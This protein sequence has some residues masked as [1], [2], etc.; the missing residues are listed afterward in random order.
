M[1]KTAARVRRPVPDSS[2]L[3]GLG[4]RLRKARTE[5]GLSQG[6]L[7]APH[8]TRAYISAVE[9]GKIRPSVKSLEFMAAKLGKPTSYFMEEQGA[10]TRDREVRAR[11]RHAAQLVAEGRSREAIRQLE[12]LLVV[13]SGRQRAEI[14]R[15]LGRAYTDVGD[16]GAAIAQ[17]NDALTAFVRMGDTENALR[18]RAQLGA[19]LVLGK[20]YAEASVHL[21]QVLA[22]FAAGTAKDPLV[23]LQALHHL[24]IIFY[25]RGDFPTALSHFDRA[26]LEGQDVGDPRFLGSTYAASGMSRYQ[27]GDFEGAISCFLKSEAI[28][29]SIRKDERVINIQ[30]QT[31]IA[32]RSLGNR[33]KSLETARRAADR[34]KAIGNRELMIRIETFAAACAAELGD[35]SWAVAELERLV[36]EADAT[37]RTSLRF[38]SRFG[39]GRVLKTVDPGRAENV[40]REAVALLEV[41]EPSAELADAYTELSDVLSRKGEPRAALEFANKAL[42]LVRP[43]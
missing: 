25:D 5:A 32:L 12:D 10:A 2:A 14:Q 34:A 26:L 33:A 37:D 7:G 41:G 3:R 30:F 4:A 23:K 31:A 21:E 1:P 16:S 28:F 13:S 18:A 36:K 39:L 22:S 29:E 9:L 27:T 42:R 40:L 11:V 20:S 24:G 8:F 19:A 43:K 15:M 35:E 38:I 6:Q 17:L